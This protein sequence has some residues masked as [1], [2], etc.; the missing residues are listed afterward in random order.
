M[1]KEKAAIIQ[2]DNLCHFRLSCLLADVFCLF[3]VT[4]FSFPLSKG[5]AFY[6]A[7]VEKKNIVF[8]WCCLDK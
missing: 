2:H 7:T 4:P 1:L 8:N 6:Q 5:L 3:P